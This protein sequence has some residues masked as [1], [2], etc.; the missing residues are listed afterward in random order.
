MITR[1]GQLVAEAATE[2]LHASFGI[3]DLSLAPTAAVGDSVAQVLEE[4]GLESCGGPGTTAALA[5]LND[6]V[7]RAAS[8]RLLVL[9][10]CR[11]HLFRS[12][13]TSV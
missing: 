11:E 10:A 3:V 6:S 5:L 8:W 7:K 4:M 12:A 1:L 2:R 13:K 9:E